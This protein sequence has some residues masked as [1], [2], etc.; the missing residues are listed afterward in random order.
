MLDLPLIDIAF[1]YNHMVAMLIT[2][3]GNSSRRG[4]VVEI[5]RQLKWK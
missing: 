2:Q 3:S 4:R 5:L 1:Q